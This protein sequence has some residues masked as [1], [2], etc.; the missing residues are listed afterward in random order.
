MTIAMVKKEHLAIAEEGMKDVREW[1][2]IRRAYYVKKQSKRQV[3][4]E[5]RCSYETVQK[6]LKYSAPQPYTLRKPR[7]SPV[8]GPH[9]EEIGR[10]LEENVRLPRKQ[11]YTSHTIYKQIKQQGYRGSESNLRRYIGQ[12]RR[13]QRR[14]AVYLPL[15]YE[16]GV[17]GQVDWGEAQVELCGERTVVQLFIMRLCY[18]RKLFVMAFPTQRQEAF[19]A[20]HAAAFR[21]FGGVPQRLSYDNLKVAVNRILR[22][23]N[24]QEQEAFVAFRSHYL[25]ASHYCTPGEGHEKGGVENGVGYVQRNFLTAVPKVASFSEL[26][27]QLLAACT[28]EEERQVEGVPQSIGAMWQAEKGLLYPLPAQDFLCCRSREVTL[29]GYSQVSFESNRYSVPVQLARKELVLRAYPFEVEIL[30]G[31]Q[32]IARHPR[33]YGHQQTLLDPLHYLSLLEKR[34]GAFEH[35]KPLREWRKSWPPL[36]EELLTYLRQRSAA[37]GEPESR[38]IREFIGVLQLHQ[39]HP[40]HL[41][42]AAIRMAMEQN[43]LHLAGVRYCLNGLLHP[44]PVRLSLELTTYPQLREMGGQPIDATRY[45]RLLAVRL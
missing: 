29:N 41:I 26:N 16:P 2:K 17:D 1:E 40:A 3:M 42:E 27:E 8:L 36:Y 28:A 20:G 45:D 35:A 32:V 5:L 33:C 4:R 22:G 30:D 13:E 37:A 6:A 18:S 39:Q 9:K 24:R 21:Y 10:L 25:F 44:A 14:P 38:A 11:R 19:F 15:S 31:E 12:V 43:L 34:P 23:K 7:R